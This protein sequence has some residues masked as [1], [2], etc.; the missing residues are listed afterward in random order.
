MKDFKQKRIV[1]VRSQKIKDQKDLVMMKLT[2]YYLQTKL[3]EIENDAS[4]P[5]AKGSLSIEGKIQ[6]LCECFGSIDLALHSGMEEYGF[7]CLR[8]TLDQVERLASE[9]GLD[10]SIDKDDLEAINSLE[11]SC[12]ILHRQIQ[13][14]IGQK[15][16]DSRIEE[17][18]A[19]LRELGVEV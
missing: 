15:S 9:V 11:E 19:E 12:E 14:A 4:N 17:L 5:F 6:E 2:M 10:P 16:K 7:E 8:T 18:K 3:G 13:L 1:M